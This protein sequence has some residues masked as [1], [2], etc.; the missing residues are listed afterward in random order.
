MVQVKGV[1]VPVIHFHFLKMLFVSHGPKS[2]ID[3]AWK[4]FVWECV[5]SGMTLSSELR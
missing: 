4:L 2:F 3:A 1:I 5:R